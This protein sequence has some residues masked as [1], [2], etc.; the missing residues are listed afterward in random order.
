MSATPSIASSTVPIRSGSAIADSTPAAS[1][2]CAPDSVRLVP[3]TSQPSACRAP[4]SSRPAQ[5]QP[6]ISARATRG[7]SYASLDPELVL[8]LVEALLVPAPGPIAD[9]LVLPGHRVGIVLR[10]IGDA[11]PP[12]V[13]V[14][15]GDH[16]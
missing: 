12:A 4:P 5:P 14:L 13:L 3:R 15:R 6:T 2:A 9:G 1:I 16:L 8:E 7:R 11:A 10:H